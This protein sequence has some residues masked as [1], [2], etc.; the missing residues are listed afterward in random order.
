MRVQVRCAAVAVS[1][2]VALTG[3]SGCY[4]QHLV[5]ADHQLDMDARAESDAKITDASP[6]DASWNTM[7]DGSLRDASLDAA[8][9]AA[10][11]S[12]VHDAAPEDAGIA[13][14]PAQ[15]SQTGLFADFAQE[16]LA[17]GVRAF[18]PKYKL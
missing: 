8:L 10:L 3:S 7:L 1:V 17:P 11:D 4:D 2:A 12:A 6:Q 14:L 16:A 9:D 15:L 13:T 5:P 18:E